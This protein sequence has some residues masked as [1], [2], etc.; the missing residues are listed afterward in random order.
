M[1]EK[2]KQVALFCE[3]CNEEMGF[4]WM[5]LTVETHEFYLP[6]VCKNQ[7]CTEYRKLFFNNLVQLMTEALARIKFESE[8]LPEE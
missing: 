1:R 5:I 4:G 2:V 3:V 8:D 7:V 6:I